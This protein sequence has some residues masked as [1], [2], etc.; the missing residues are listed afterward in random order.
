MNGGKQTMAATGETIDPHD[1][2]P[3]PA[4]DR[5]D[6]YVQRWVAGTNGRLY[7]PLIN[8]LPRYPI[9]RWPGDLPV[10][11]PS[12]LLDIGC[13]WGRWMVSAGRVGYTPIGMDIKVDAVRAA[14]R[15]LRAHNLAGFVVVAD[16]KKLPF[17]DGVFD[18]VFSYSVIQH[19]HREYARECLNE[20]GRVMKAGALSFLEFPMRSGLANSRRRVAP[21]EDADYSS[22]CVRY[23][24]LAELREMLLRTIGAPQ[25]IV[26]CYL[27]IG[28]RPED[29]DLLE[30]RHKLIPVASE[31]MKMMSKVVPP[32]QRIADS[33]FVRA[34]KP[35]GRVR[36]DDTAACDSSS[37]DNLAVIP[38]LRCP[39]SGAKLEYD[40]QSKRL[41]ARQAG[42]A[43]PVVDE[44]PILL[45]S[46]AENV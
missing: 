16:L 5:V 40:A 24:T 33:V 21:D 43:Y 7:I 6:Q 22:W 44:I 42:L 12:I 46:A 18:Y 34:Q 1:L 29:L 28:V 3:P 25:F 10:G 45:E 15:V 17:A 11:K 8:K 32:L 41:V 37:Q 35:G 36:R 20:C 9:P 19:V 27:G 4:H 26:N 13:S 14:R 38:L 30:W 2:I 39:I 23:Y 31:L